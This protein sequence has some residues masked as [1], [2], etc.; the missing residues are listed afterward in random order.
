MKTVAI[1]ALVLGILFVIS[2]IVIKRATNRT[3]GHQYTVLKEYEDFEIRKYES[4]LFS[5][6]VMQADAYKNVSSTGFR[7]LAG[8]IFGGNDKNQKIAMTSPVAMSMDDSITMK[9]KIPDGLSSDE[10]PKPT[11]PEV[12]FTEEPEKIVAALRFGGKTTDA[13]IATNIEKLKRAL[14]EENIEHTSHFSYLGYNPPYEVIGRR[15]EVIVE[16]PSFK[17]D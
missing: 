13:R 2:Q 10:L 5:Y 16:L 8:Y 15:N 12:H 7:R 9:F 17:T 14:S 4:A 11:N 6:T 3:E 1:V